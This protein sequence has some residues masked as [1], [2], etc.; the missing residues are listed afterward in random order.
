[1]Q[2]IMAPSLRKSHVVMNLELQENLTLDSFPGALTQVLMILINNAIT[3][4]FEGR[5]Q[6]KIT[7]TASAEEAERVRIEVRDDGVGIA[8]AN[9]ARVF[10]PF[11]TTKLGKGGSGLGMH[12]CFNIVHGNAGRQSQ[13]AQCSG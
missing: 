10:E 2:I 6:G 9:L 13:C 3:H 8:P 4:A 7:L 5:D 12:I 11:F 1:M